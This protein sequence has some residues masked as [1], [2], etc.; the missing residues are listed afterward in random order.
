VRDGEYSDGGGKGAHRHPKELSQPNWKD[1]P[2]LH[3]EIWR[4][5]GSDKD[6]PAPDVYTNPT[7]MG[8]MRN[9]YEKLIGRSDPGVITGKAIADG[10]SAG[11]ETATAK[12]GVFVVKELAK[13]LNLNPRETKVAV[14]GMGTW[15]VHGENFI[16]RGLPSRGFKR[17]AGRSL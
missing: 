13:K 15:A 11:R 3:P 7:I 5:I 6:V 10:G 14:Q 8:W 2:A 17:F 4:E 12:G 16:G 9:E 1:C